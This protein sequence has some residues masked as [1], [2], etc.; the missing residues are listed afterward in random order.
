MRRRH[1][2]RVF[3]IGIR[4]ALLPHFP[5]LNIGVYDMSA[6]IASLNA[7]LDALIAAVNALPS[8]PPPA[9]VVATQ[10]DLDALA[11]K[12]AAVDAAVAAKAVVPI[13]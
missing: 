11:V 4:I 8:V 3:N 1:K 6:T 10:E 2:K 12:V 5:Y 13:I 9:I 7:S